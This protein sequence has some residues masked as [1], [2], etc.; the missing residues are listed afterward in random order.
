MTCVVGIEY[1]GRV[2]MASDSSSVSGWDKTSISFPKMFYVRGLMI[3]YTSS[4]RMG[5][6]LEYELD[7]PARAS[8]ESKIGYIIKS[9]VPAIRSVLKDHGYMGSD[10]ERREYG[11]QLMIGCDGELFVVHSDFQVSRNSCG[12]AAIGVGAA[13]AYGSMFSS[14]NLAGD[15]SPDVRLHEAMTAAAEFCIGV[16][17]PISIGFVGSSYRIGDSIVEPIYRVVS[18]I[19]I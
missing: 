3:G 10:S 16:S 13:Y 18:N 8:G 9:V 19:E 17:G 11:G 2:Y 12:Y 4:F 6:I 14:G 1:D 7:V 15:A 5:Q